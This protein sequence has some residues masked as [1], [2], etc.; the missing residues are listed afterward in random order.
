MVIF[1]ILVYLVFFALIYL[2][3]PELIELPKNRPV[4]L[5]YLTVILAVIAFYISVL[6]SKLF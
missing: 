5:P 4:V 3:R 2:L 1:A 6:F